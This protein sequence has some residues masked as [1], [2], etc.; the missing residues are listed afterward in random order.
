MTALC[1]GIEA[2]FVDA[3]S[4][5]TWSGDVVPD[6]GTA[7]PDSTLLG[8]PIGSSGTITLE[9]PTDID[10]CG[11]TQ[12]CMIVFEDFVNGSPPARVYASSSGTITLD[13]PTTAGTASGLLDA[14][15][16]VEVTLDD[17][18]GGLTPVRD[19]QCLILSDGSFEFQSK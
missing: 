17:A 5:S 9:L 10:D 14:V 15:E 3:E 1:T 12:A 6:L 8:I 11:D 18:T 4:F 7:E 16:L 19:G 2:A 13:A